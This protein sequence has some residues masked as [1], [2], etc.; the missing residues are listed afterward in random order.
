MNETVLS[1]GNQHEDYRIGFVD[2][3]LKYE[4][5]RIR[6]E[7]IQVEQDKDRNRDEGMEL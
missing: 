4:R 3:G 2:C 6:Q 7:F 5:N 1:V